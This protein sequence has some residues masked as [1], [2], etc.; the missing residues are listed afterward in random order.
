MP[1]L[2]KH[3]LA[4]PQLD[5][6]PTPTMYQRRAHSPDTHQS[7]E[8]ESFQESDRH[9]ESHR[10][11]QAFPA[12][13]TGGT[14]G[15]HHGCMV[16]TIGRIGL[17]VS[18]HSVSTVQWIECKASAYLKR[19]HED[20]Q[21]SERHDRKQNQYAANMSRRL[22]VAAPPAPIRRR[23]EKRTPAERARS[24]HLAQHL[25]SLLGSCGRRVGISLDE[26]FEIG[27]V[28]LPPNG[29]HARR[30]RSYTGLRPRCLIILI[31]HTAPPSSC[32]DVNLALIEHCRPHI[33]PTATPNRFGEYPLKKTTEN[34]CFTSLCKLDLQI[35][36]RMP[37]KL[38]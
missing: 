34:I 21:T 8:E 37:D 6:V 20:T 26:C 17:P 15:S 4:L 25:R 22:P 7:N 13:A 9:I 18:P 32:A 14:H 12:R 27:A 24:S 5:L 10:Q 35:R 38:R 36:D 16:D 28:S 1:F 30:Y 29:S 11:P 19:R 3:R 2:S 31:S 23:K 33:N